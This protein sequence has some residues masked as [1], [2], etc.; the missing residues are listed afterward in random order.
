MSDLVL[1]A[2]AML[3]TGLVGG[4]LAGVLGIGGGIVIVPMLEFALGIVG[5][6][7][8]IRMHIAVATSLATIIPTSVASARAHHRRRSVDLAVARRW[9]PWV[10]AGSLA[11]SWVASQVDSKVLAA[12][13]ASLAV[14]VAARMIL[15]LK[16][17]P[18]A[19]A[20]PDSV[21]MAPVPT[22]IGFVS[23]MVGIG[24]GSLSVPAMTLLGA[25]IHRAVGT[26]A[27][28]GLVIAVPGA[29]GFVLTG[30]GHPLL[31]AG[32]LGYVNLIGFVLIA[33]TT[34]LAAPLGARLA[35]AMDARQLSVLFG[36]FLLLVSV[37]MFLRAFA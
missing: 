2:L 5:V 4:V 11:G 10:F 21:T 31:P 8:S 18:L 15:D 19:P 17:R 36:G 32:S 22:L 30:W 16:E 35:H 12:M 23:S 26:A 27:L 24:G 20:V 25:P 37:R 6:D 9:S 1:L 7:A 28:F 13:F 34:V 33:P 3:G 14:L 29:L